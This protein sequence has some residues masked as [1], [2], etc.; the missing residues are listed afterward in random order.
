[1]KTQVFKNKNPFLD[2]FV[3]RT[4]TASLSSPLNDLLLTN[5][6]VPERRRS[7]RFYCR[8]ENR[9]VSV[10]CRLTVAGDR[11]GHLHDLSGPGEPPLYLHKSGHTHGIIIAEH[12]CDIAEHIVCDIAEHIM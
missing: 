5:R 8:R 9:L 11:L 6:H 4:H 3:Q 12:I 7:N 10:L 2:V 1:M